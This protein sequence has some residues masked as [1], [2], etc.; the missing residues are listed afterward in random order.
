MENATFN[1]VCSSCTCDQSWCLHSSCPSWPSN[2]SGLE[3][4]ALDSGLQVEALDSGL[5]VEALDSG[6]EVWALES[7]FEEW[8]LDGAGGSAS[9]SGARA[10]PIRPM[11][12]FPV[13]APNPSLKKDGLKVTWSAHPF[14]TNTAKATVAAKSFI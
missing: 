14:Q 1:T 13:L 6:L 12:P 10:D 11:T 4:G 5:E 3:V 9:G 7:G 8:G 2:N